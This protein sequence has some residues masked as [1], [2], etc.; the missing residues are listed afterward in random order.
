[1]PKNCT[2][3]MLRGEVL[4]IFILAEFASQST[5]PLVLFLLTENHATKIQL[6]GGTGF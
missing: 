4:T 1:M 6:D 2:I 5:N 3:V